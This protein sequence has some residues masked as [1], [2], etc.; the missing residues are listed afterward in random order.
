MHDVA[1]EPRKIT[2]ERQKEWTVLSAFCHL[3]IY[4]KSLLIFWP[5]KFSIGRLRASLIYRDN[6]SALRDR[7]D[8]T[9]LLSQCWVG[10]SASSLRVFTDRNITHDTEMFLPTVYSWWYE[11]LCRWCCRDGGKLTDTVIYKRQNKTRW[12]Q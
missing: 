1:A 9:V 11:K 7:M 8:H 2:V 12:I 3:G 4:Y 6:D 10:S 5:L